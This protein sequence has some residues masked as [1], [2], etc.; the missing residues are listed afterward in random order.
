MAVS[1]DE[2]SAL[3]P[4]VIPYSHDSMYHIVGCESG[5][6]HLRRVQLLYRVGIGLIDPSLS[7]SLSTS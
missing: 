4:T 2:M 1:D 7:D 3:M 6:Q 5:V